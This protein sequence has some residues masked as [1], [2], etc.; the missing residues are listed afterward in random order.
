MY[1]HFR[2][3][4]KVFNPFRKAKRRSWKQEIISPSGKTDRLVNGF[5]SPGTKGLPFRIRKFWLLFHDTRVPCDKSEIFHK[6]TRCRP[7][8]FTETVRVLLVRVAFMPSAVYRV[9]KTRPWS[10]FNLQPHSPTR[11]TRRVR[12]VHAGERTGVR[13]KTNHDI[14]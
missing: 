6:D 14:G 1:S 4:N 3:W 11:R 13:K 9:T 2:Q 5:P 7:S 10:N 12:H 8:L